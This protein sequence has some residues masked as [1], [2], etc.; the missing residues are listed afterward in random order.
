MERLKEETLRAVSREL[1]CHDWTRAELAE[2]VA[3][4]FGVIT[5]FQDLLDALEQLRQLDLGLIPPAQ[6]IQPPEVGDA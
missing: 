4:R 3:P 1:A 2:L 6:G 5:G